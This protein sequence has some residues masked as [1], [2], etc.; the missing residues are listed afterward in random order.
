M[1]DA[2]SVLENGVTSNTGRRVNFTSP[3]QQTEW[4][5]THRERGWAQKNITNAFGMVHCPAD[6]S[7][8]TYLSN[9]KFKYG[10]PVSA[11]ARGSC[12]PY[13]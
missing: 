12:V 11:E 10:P 4:Y 13:S 8:Q 6:C 3:W 2:I 9:G 7:S 5:E 1:T